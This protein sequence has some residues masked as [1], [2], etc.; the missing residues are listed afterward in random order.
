MC[1]AWLGAAACEPLF[2]LGLCP[3]NYRDLWSSGQEGLAMLW[4]RL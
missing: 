2:W 4:S 1:V 3:C